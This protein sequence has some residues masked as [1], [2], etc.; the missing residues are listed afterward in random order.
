MASALAVIAL[1]ACGGGPARQDENEPRRVYKVEVVRAEF[2]PD[3]KL[4]RQ[5]TMEIVVRN[6]DT[7]T[8]PNVSVTVKDFDYRRSS[9]QPLADQGRPIFVVNTVPRRQTPGALPAGEIERTSAY[10]DTWTLGRLKP[11]Q[12][13]TFRWVVTAVEARRY[14]LAWRVHAGLDGKAQAVLPDGS[15]PRGVF[16]G[17]IIEDAPSARVADDGTTIVTEDG[18]VITGPEGSGRPRS[19]DRTLDPGRRKS[20]LPVP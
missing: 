7:R 17:R 12:T 13:K 6:A 1:P 10:S 2:P 19:D 11:G 8:I 20:T 3:Q 15:I 18:R 9:E 4:A 5:S 14:R 16:S